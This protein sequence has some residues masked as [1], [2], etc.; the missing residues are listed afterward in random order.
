MN[1][2][3][4]L[5]IPQGIFIKLIES[6]EVQELPSQKNLYIQNAKRRYFS[7][8]IIIPKQRQGFNLYVSGCV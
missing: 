8:I 1:E 4:T 7:D 5:N 2:I 6:I 3:K